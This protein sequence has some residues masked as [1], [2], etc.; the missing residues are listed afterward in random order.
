VVKNPS[1]CQCRRHGLNPWVRKIPWRRNWQ[2]T[3]VFLSG[4]F[5]GQRSL[6]GYSPWGHKESD[7]TEWRHTHTH[8]QSAL[9]YCLWMVLWLNFSMFWLL[10]HPHP[11]ARRGGGILLG[12]YWQKQKIKKDTDANERKWRG[13]HPNPTLVITASIL[14]HLNLNHFLCKLFGTETLR[15]P[16]GEVG[17]KVRPRNREIKGAETEKRNTKDG[18][19]RQAEGCVN[20]Q[21]QGEKTSLDSTGSS[22]GRPLPQLCLRKY[23]RGIKNV[24]MILH[25][26]WFS[27]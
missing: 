9:Q 4:K 3:P 25:H 22:L 6:V 18:F 2:P 17:K 8:T 21:R 12:S 16:S 27:F 23:I 10:D 13:H 5:H 11:P 26:P 20:E 15:C 19:Q 1:A 24:I 7:M 14:L